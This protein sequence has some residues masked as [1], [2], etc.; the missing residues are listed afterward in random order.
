[1]LISSTVE[2]L[3]A[4]CQRSQILK[5]FISDTAHLVSAVLLKMVQADRPVGWIVVIFCRDIRGSQRINPTHF[6]LCHHEKDI[7]GF[8]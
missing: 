2:Q 8:E 7:F 5:R 6:L 3:P 4:K 1:M